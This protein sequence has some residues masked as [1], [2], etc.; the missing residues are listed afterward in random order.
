M[1]DP[2]RIDRLSDPTP[3]DTDAIRHGLVEFNRQVLGPTEHHP[4]VFHLRG[5]DG[6]FLGG[7]NGDVWL[8]QLTVEFLWVDESLRGQGYGHE[9]LRR[10]E[11]F[12]VERGATVAYLDTFDFQ[13]GP[14]YYERQ[15]YQVFGVVGDPP[16]RQSFFM[17]KRLAPPRR[18]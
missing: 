16:E 15:G 5:A 4:V 6:K 8:G 2:V 13:A 11:R 7:L 3:A 10:A 18:V 14:A 9:L 1:S 17:R 12:A